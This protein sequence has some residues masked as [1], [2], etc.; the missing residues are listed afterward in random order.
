VPPAPGRPKVL[1]TSAVID[2]RVLDLAR[3]GFLEG[4]LVVPT[5]VLDELRRIA[6]S[7]EPVRRQRGRHG[8]EVLANLQKELGGRVVVTDQ[9]PAP[10]QDVD[11]RLVLLAKAL[12]AEV[13]STDANLDKVAELQGVTVLN[14]NELASVLRPQYLP[15]EAL[16]V[17]IVADGK[18]PG[19]GV[20][21]LVDG[22]MVVVEGGRRFMN[23]EVE[24]EVTSS[25]QTAQG[26]MLFGR[27][28]ERR[29]ERVGRA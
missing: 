11:Q 14:V 4:E 2:G 22:T 3:T 16:A 13:V 20:G 23:E 7:P 6:D 12:G 19:Q 17:R 15:G 26:R 10:G 8:L 1:D 21:Y 25:Y 5:W 24:V 29:L 27:P 9:D 18:Q 28:R